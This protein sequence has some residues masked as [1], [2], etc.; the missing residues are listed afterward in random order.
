MMNA[1]ISSAISSSLVHCS[2]Y[3]VTG[4]RPRPYTDT[5]PFS[6]LVLRPMNKTD[7]QGP[8]FGEDFLWALLAAK[9]SS[10]GR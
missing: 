2:L 9:E 1:R 7:G 10:G 3:S 5:P 6:L 4:K 8:C